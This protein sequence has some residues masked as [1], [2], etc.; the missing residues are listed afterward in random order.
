M[1]MDTGNS[2]NDS[3]STDM[4]S[5]ATLMG[6]TLSNNKDGNNKSETLIKSL[7]FVGILFKFVLGILIPSNKSAIE[8]STLNIWTNIIIIFALTVN[9]FIL[10]KGENSSLGVEE[11]ASSLIIIGLLWQLMITYKHSEIININKVP[12]IYSN[13]NITYNL[14][15]LIYI[16]VYLFGSGEKGTSRGSLLIVI[17]ILSFITILIIQVILDIF[18]VDIYR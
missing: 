4:S 5:L 7:F 11:L 6:S 15:L 18:M 1:L 16:V 14:L 17:S 9:L 3:S 8:R 13:W 2:N 12:S 10:N